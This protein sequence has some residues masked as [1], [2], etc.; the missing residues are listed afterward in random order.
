MSGL[1]VGKLNVYVTNHSRKEKLL[2]RLF[3][4]QNGTWVEAL[5]P[6]DESSLQY[7][8]NMN[9]YLLTKILLII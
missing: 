7:Q 4:H 2:W 8:V 5:V 9:F 1:H 6:V 3:G